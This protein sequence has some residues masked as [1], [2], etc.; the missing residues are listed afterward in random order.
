MNG[1]SF[2]IPLGLKN[3][4]LQDGL[5]M[6]VG[7]PHKSG[8]LLANA[9]QN[10]YAVM[11][12]AAAFWNAKKQK[13]EMPE[14]SPLHELDF[15]LDSA[16]FTAMLGFKKKRHLDGI[17]NIFPWTLKEYLSFACTSGATW[18]SSSDLCCEAEIANSQ[19]EVQYRHRHD[20][21]LVAP[22]T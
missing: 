16:G 4:H 15:A 21:R 8:S 13:L 18:F 6:R 2:G 22:H 19:D 1:S 9:E 7:I 14:Y 5:Q 10:G 20:R 17:A 12:S 11:V 3:A